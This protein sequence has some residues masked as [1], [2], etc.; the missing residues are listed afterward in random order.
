MLTNSLTSNSVRPVGSELTA[1]PFAV[2][3]PVCFAR[4]EFNCKQRRWDT[5]KLSDPSVNDN[6][7]TVASEA[8]VRQQEKN[9]SNSGKT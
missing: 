8:N 7:Q 2:N 9:K 4:N 3:S 6:I 1:V 5:S